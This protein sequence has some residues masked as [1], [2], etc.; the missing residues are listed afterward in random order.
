MRTTTRAAKAPAPAR[1]ESTEDHLERI[2]ELIDRKGY[3]RVAD[4]AASLRLSTS[5][6]SNMVRRLARRGYVNYERYRGFTL[7][8]AGR[9]VAQHVKARHNALTDFLQIV[10][11][12]PETVGREVEEIEHHLRP[13]T[14]AILE[15]LVSFW[16]EHPVQLAAFKRYARKAPPRSA[17][18]QQKH[19]NAD[20][21]LHPAGG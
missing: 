6:V 16:R 17:G 14:L 21:V 13:E 11:L 1:S 10:G 8:S 2:Q 19:G 9:Q 12:D 7:T 3:A 5:A 15:K 20:T 18:P 4:L